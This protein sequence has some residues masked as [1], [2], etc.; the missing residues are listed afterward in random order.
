ME[1]YDGMVKLLG[2]TMSFHLTL[3]LVVCGTL[4]MV[5][6]GN[7]VYMDQPTLVTVQISKLINPFHQIT[8]LVMA[9]VE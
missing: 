4:I 8:S 2:N 5:V 1:S 9:L 6:W 3:I 7:K